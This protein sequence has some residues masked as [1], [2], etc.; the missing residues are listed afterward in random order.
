MAPLDSWDAA[1]NASPRV[2][3]VPSGRGLD[4]VA[5]VQ[6]GLY[7]GEAAVESGRKT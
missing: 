4:P 1:S 5:P 6:V 2:G 3:A 7:G